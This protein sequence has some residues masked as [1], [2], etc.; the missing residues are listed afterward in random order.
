MPGAV[1][2]CG[3][4]GSCAFHIGGI[5]AGLACLISGIIGISDARTFEHFILNIYAMAFGFWIFILEIYQPSWFLDKF[6]FYDTMP[7]RGFFILFVGCL[8]LGTT[9]FQRFLGGLGIFVAF[10]YLLLALILKAGCLNPESPMLKRHQIDLNDLP[11]PLYKS[12]T[13]KKGTGAYQAPSAGVEVPAHEYDQNGG[14][15]HDD[16][17]G[18]TVVVESRDND[19]KLESGNPYEDGGSYNAN[20]VTLT[21]DQVSSAASFAAKNP[22]MVS[23][24]INMVSKVSKSALR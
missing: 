11:E 12:S 23:G 21:G 4:I 22:E 17:G 7:G 6:G 20:G 13:G 2:T 14:G 8:S 18:N 15:M 19:T 10:C 3:G 1:E 5:V 16:Q 24:T 9:S